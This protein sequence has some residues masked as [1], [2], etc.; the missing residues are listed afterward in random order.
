MTR[1]TQEADFAEPAYVV[2]IG[3]IVS[4]RELKGSSRRT[5]QEHLTATLTQLNRT[6]KQGLLARLT[7]T[8]GDEFQTVIRPAFAEKLVPDLIWILEQELPGISIRFGVGLGNIDTAISPNPL[9]MDGSAFHAARAAIET[10]A[11]EEKMGGVF[12]GFGQRH[13]AV[14]NGIARILHHHRNDWSAQQRRVADL[15]RNGNRQNK[16]ASILR[17]SK[18]AVSSYARVAA[19]QAYSEGEVAWRV[20]LSAAVSQSQRSAVTADA[21]PAI[22][23]LSK[24]ASR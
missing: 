10:A 21:S 24:K 4:S 12:A 17:L 8:L 19:W 20:A 15:L 6:F 1:T 7:I 9:M 2:L 18:Q 16:A 23:G 13:D 3:D 5:A 11:A 14:L 22:A